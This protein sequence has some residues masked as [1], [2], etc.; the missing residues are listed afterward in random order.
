MHEMVQG[1][2]GIV[3]SYLGINLALKTPP[4]EESVPAKP[5]SDRDSD[6]LRQ[7]HQDVLRQVLLQYTTDQRRQRRE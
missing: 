4:A 2:K 5:V 7:C 3:G 1:K 6:R